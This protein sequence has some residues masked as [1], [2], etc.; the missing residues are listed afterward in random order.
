[1]L[2]VKQPAVKR[3]ELRLAA[4]LREQEKKQILRFGA[5]ACDLNHKILYEPSHR[6]CRGIG[7][8]HV[9]L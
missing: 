3:P 4:D 9:S 1:M 5:Q 6:Q 8:T 7:E 2:G